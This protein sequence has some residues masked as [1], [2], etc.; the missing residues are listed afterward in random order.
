MVV[1]L[2][3]LHAAAPPTKKSLFNGPLSSHAFNVVFLHPIVV[4][5][6]L[7]M[8]AAYELSP[9]QMVAASAVAMCL[10]T[11][12]LSLLCYVIPVEW[13][14]PFRKKGDASVEED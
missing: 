3:A 10:V 5:F 4:M 8:L 7:K 6:V 11:L 2:F 9:V 13:L 1:C 12:T 14:T